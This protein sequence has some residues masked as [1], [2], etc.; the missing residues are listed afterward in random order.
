MPNVGDCGSTETLGAVDMMVLYTH[1]W[2]LLPWISTQ[3]LQESVKPQLDSVKL[4]ELGGGK[5]AFPQGTGET[6]VAGK[7]EKKKPSVREDQETILRS[8]CERK[9][10]L[11][12][13]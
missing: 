10:M 6:H 9:L 5:L 13:G 1:V 12:K 4:L 8:D 7:S 2:A 3:L 11:E